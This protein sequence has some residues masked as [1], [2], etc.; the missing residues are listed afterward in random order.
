[1]SADVSFHTDVNMQ[2]LIDNAID[3]YVADTLFRKRDPRFA[4]ASK[5]K[6]S[7]ES[8]AQHFPPARLPLRPRQQRLH[9]PGR[10]VSLPNGSHCNIGGREAVK[11]TSAHPVCG[12]CQIRHRCLRHPE[13]TPVRQIVFFTGQQHNPLH[14]YTEQMKRRIDIER[15]RHQ[16]AKRLATVEPVFAHITSKGLRRFSHRGEKKVNAQWLLYCLVHNIEKVQR[17]G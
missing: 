2:Y 12:P 8:K 17:Y 6:R 7:K 13:R 11:F 5:Y 10:R 1:M 16:C 3:G 14:T 4:E 9:L 15:G